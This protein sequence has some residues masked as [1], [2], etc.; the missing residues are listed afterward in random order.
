MFKIDSLIL[1]SAQKQSLIALTDL[2]DK[3]FSL[4]WRGSK[5]GFE[6]STFHRLC[7]DKG[8]TL[9]VIKDAENCIFGGFT[10]VPWSTEGFY[11]SDSTAFLFTL[12]NPS[13]TPMKL[14]VNEPEN[15]VLHS[16]LGP[17]FGWGYDLFVSCLSNTNRRSCMLLR[18]Y[19]NELPNGKKGVGRFIIGAEYYKFKTME[20]EVFKVL[21]W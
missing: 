13:G 14:K 10:S 3:F 5:H 15:A 21:G 1:S 8:K 2:K 18:S 19:D 7:D 17:T 9:L 20:V 6:D 12:T 4:L 16:S 11:K